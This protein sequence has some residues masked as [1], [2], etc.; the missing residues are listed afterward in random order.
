MP[1]AAANFL[2][3]DFGSPEGAAAADAALKA[4]GVIVRR[5]G[6]YGLGQ[7]LRVSIGTAED[8]ALVAE[9]LAAFMA[10]RAVHA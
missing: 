4:R 3:A 1:Q 5:L 10:E 6:G 9:I 2:L 7:Y 8:C